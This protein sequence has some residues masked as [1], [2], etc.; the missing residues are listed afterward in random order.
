MAVL[1]YLHFY[2]LHALLYSITFGL[3]RNMLNFS[4]GGGTD[5]SAVEETCTACSVTRQTLMGNQAKALLVSS[6]AGEYHLV[7]SLSLKLA[8]VRVCQFVIWIHHR[9]RDSS[10]DVGFK[11]NKQTW[12]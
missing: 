11:T 10:V 1:F 6:R 12:S 5:S 8:V 4:I 2:N 9:C 3:C 7:S